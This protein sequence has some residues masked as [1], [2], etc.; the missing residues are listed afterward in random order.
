MTT[1]ET[2]C[3]AIGGC[4]VCKR[5][6]RTIQ[7]SCAQVAYQPTPRPRYAAVRRVNRVPIGRQARLLL[8]CQP[9]LLS[10]GWWI[11]MASPHIDDDPDVHHCLRARRCRREL[12][13]ALAKRAGV[14]RLRSIVRR[15]CLRARCSDHRG[16]AWRRTRCRQVIG[17]AQHGSQAGVA[18]PHAAGPGSRFLRF[19][20]YARLPPR[21]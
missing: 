14:R 20:R 15:E 4:D 9:R 2:E 1:K 5:A 18:R 19:S 7:Q 10:G 8:N 17:A 6:P 11:G 3:K 21:I 12:C 13:L 16:E